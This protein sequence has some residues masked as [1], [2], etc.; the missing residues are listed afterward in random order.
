MLIAPSAGLARV[1]SS[2]FPSI[3]RQFD[4]YHRYVPHQRLSYG[5]RAGR[6]RRLASKVLTGHGMLASC[7]SALSL[8]RPQPFGSIFSIQR[9]HDPR[10]RRFHG[11][12]SY[13]ADGRGF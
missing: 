6:M 7:L 4:V 11:K 12:L 9:L 2:I 10:R 5:R 1:H 13:G 3:E 8:E